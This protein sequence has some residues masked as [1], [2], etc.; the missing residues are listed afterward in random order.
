MSTVRE[1]LEDPH[2]AAR[3]YYEQVEHPEVGAWAMHGWLWRTT[4]AGPCV[5]APAPDLGSDNRAIL[6]ELLGLDDAA[7]DALAESGVIGDAPI[8]ER[9]R[10]ELVRPK[11]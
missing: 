2:L 11:A 5:L 8:G 10:S 4:D 3:G 1:L 9:P 6:G 7:I